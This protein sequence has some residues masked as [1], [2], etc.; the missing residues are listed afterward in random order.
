M[1]DETDE[2]TAVKKPNTQ[3]VE[4]SSPI[5]K[6]KNTQVGEE[7]AANYTYR[8]VA[9]SPEV[10]PR[11][12]QW[13][14]QSTIPV[15]EIKHR[16]ERERVKF[17][18]NKSVANA[19][20]E[21]LKKYGTV[22]NDG[23]RIYRSDAFAIRK[24]DGVISIH[25]RSDEA[26]GFKEP[27]MQFKLDSKGVPDIKGASLLNNL[28]GNVTQNDI[29]PI[30]KQEFLIVAERIGEGKGLPDLQSGDV[31]EM[32]NALGSLAPA[33][34][35]R[36][37]ETFKKSEMLEMLNST[38]NQTKSD[39]V[40]T[41]EFTIKRERDP[42]N[43]RASLVLTKDGDDGRGKQELVRF[44]LEKTPDG[45][46]TEVAKMN[47]SDYDIG[48]I[49]HIA[50]NAY[51]LDNKNL[52]SNFDSGNNPP[53]PQSTNP[54]QPK[55]TVEDTKTIGDI[56]VNI[57]PWI[58]KEWQK[59]A[60]ET[61]DKPLWQDVMQQDNDELLQ[62]LEAN[63]GKLPISDQREMYDKIIMHKVTQVQASGDKDAEVSFMPKKDITADLMNERSRTI[64]SQFTPTTTIPQRQA[65]P[66]RETPRPVKQ[67]Q[68][69]EL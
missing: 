25:R 17:E 9:S 69:V 33:G 18:E 22:E 7:P 19:A 32:G 65:Q 55:A 43:N 28:K 66:K 61:K 53:Q 44:N 62:K 15:Y 29:L 64:N 1:S 26:K 41:G 38:L 3:V 56:P 35:L 45:I 21:M 8:Q 16:G 50:Q 4:E 10:E 11:A 57:H 36:T 49:K 60:A 47:I 48:Q 5:V 68:G 31:R 13:A 2:L 20:T 59:M 54:T 27:L 39:E 52:E 63:A 42:E 12:Q 30:E 58:A 14:R 34:T 67:S 46:K 6:R 23:S 40:K 24:E 51:K 37:L